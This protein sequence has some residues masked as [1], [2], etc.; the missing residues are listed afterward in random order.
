MHQ[1]L[2][3]VLVIT[4]ITANCCG[5]TCK[6]S[7]LDHKVPSQMAKKN[8]DHKEDQDHDCHLNAP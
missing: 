5:K 3:I 1:M 8:S 6:M 2:V 7:G 4:V